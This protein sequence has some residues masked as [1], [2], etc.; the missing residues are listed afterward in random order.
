ML[1]ILIP[2]K[3]KE[4][5]MKNIMKLILPIIALTLLGATN[6]WSNDTTNVKNSFGY[7]DV[8][9]GV[10]IDKK[11]SSI[12]YTIIGS[13]G[14]GYRMQHNHCGCDLSLSFNELINNINFDAIINKDNAKTKFDH[15]EQFQGKALGLYYITPNAISQIYLGLGVS[16]ANNSFINSVSKII[17]IAPEM[18]VGK[19]YQNNNGK[20]R[21]F[22][23]EISM[24]KASYLS[25]QDATKFELA[26][27]YPA[28]RLSYGLGF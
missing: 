15:A 20:N 25:F 8:A 1:K 17:F 27:P 21:F 19:Q 2:N 12:D 9:A 18:V 13:L 11:D 6:A 10:A 22:Q 3:K 23:A 14:I 28:L 4:N 5:T 16:L 26:S 24:P 7:A